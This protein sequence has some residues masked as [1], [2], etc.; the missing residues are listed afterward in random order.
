M[1]PAGETTRPPFRVNVFKAIV[2]V[3]PLALLV[4]MPLVGSRSALL[5]DPGAA[6]GPRGDAR[7]G[8]WRPG[9]RVPTSIRTFAPTFFEGAGYAYH[10]VISLIVR[11]LDVRRGGPTR[12]G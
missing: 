4:A 1:L 12:A 3:L 5:R 2:P 8:S 10:H 11:G 6:A 7:S 9:W